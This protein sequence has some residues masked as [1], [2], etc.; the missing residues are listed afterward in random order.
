VGVWLNRL[1]LGW[2]PATDHNILLRYPV[3]QRV[4][5]L[6]FLVDPYK[7]FRFCGDKVDLRGWNGDSPVLRNLI[8]KLRPELVVEVGSWK[9]QSAVTLAR[10]LSAQNLVGSEL[11]CVDTWLGSVEFW[12]ERD[13]EDGYGSLNFI[14]GYPSVYY[15]FL[16]NIFGESLHQIVTPF[17]ATSWVAW[18]WFTERG[19][20]AD[21]IYI[22]ASHEYEEVFSDIKRWSKIL[23]PDGLIVGDD[24]NLSWPGVIRAY[25]EACDANVIARAGVVEEK[26]IGRKVIRRS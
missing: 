14:H 16:N 24:Y 19:L 23:K 10:E 17:P 1:W 22:D 4:R 11:V 13:H 12:R 25:E 8:R 18:K 5:D 21:L 15:T 7:D 9:G 20:Q 3:R 2:L 6:L 26:W